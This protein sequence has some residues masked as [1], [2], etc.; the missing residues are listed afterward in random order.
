MSER[1]DDRTDDS[2]AEPGWDGPLPEAVRLRVLAL[3]SDALGA[4]PDDEVPAA[5]KPFRRWAPARRTKLAAIPLAAAV[6]HDVLFRQRVATRVKRAFPDLVEALAD[7]AAPA[8]ADPVE[9]AAVAYVAR[10]PGWA[11]LVAVAGADLD[12]AATAAES[13]RATE[14]VAKLQESLAAVRAQGREEL[15]RLRDELDA[16]RAETAVVRRELRDEKG[17]RRRAEGLASEAGQRAVTTTAAS[18]TAASAVE[19]ELRR[20]R[21]RLAEAEAGLEA[22]RRATREGR[23]LEDVRLRLLL[24]TVVE[25]ATGLRRELAL[26]P[27]TTRPADLV[28][29]AVSGSALEGAAE[30]ALL[31]DDPALLDQLLGLPQVH[32]VVDGYNVTMAGYPDLSLEVQRARLVNGLVTLAAQTG[33]EVTCCFD[34][35]TVTG[36]VP[37]MSGRGV[38]VLFSKPG[39]IA[40]QLI[41]RLVRA[42]PTGRAV[43]VVSS[44]REVADGVRRSGARPVS[45]TALVRRLDRG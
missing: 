28:E 33:A 21:A 24:D 39:E 12:R 29:G 18:I 11:A 9:V 34:G 22:A 5:L 3:A 30:R 13:S 38:R 41:R 6:E 8:A 10:T 2:G 16:A 44:D 20:V 15:A 17:A 25:A 27:T 43:V 31:S 7:G 36:R 42:E 40:D 19:A 1:T 23:S 26:P 45:S 4:L 35:A 37:P 32:L 14:N